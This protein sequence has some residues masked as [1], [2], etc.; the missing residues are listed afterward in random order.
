M[1][2]KVFYRDEMTVD[3]VE[4]FSPSAGKPQKAVE[5]WLGKNL[6]IE[7]VAPR[8]VDLKDV[9]LAHCNEFVEKIHHCEV[10]NGFGTRDDRVSNAVLFTCGAM[11]EAARC[12]VEE[13]IVTCAPVSGFHHAGYDFAQYY[14][15]YNGLMVAACKLN[16]LFDIRVGILDL[17]Q[18]I[19]DGTEDIISRINADFVSHHTQGGHRCHADMA[20]Q[21]LHGLEQLIETK[22]AD[23]GIVLYQAG[24]DPHID[25]PLGGWL[26]TEQLAWR[27]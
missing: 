22:F 1:K 2:I 3:G 27:D 24:A 7:V 8:P 19:G 26:T 12:A 6:T 18:H 5:A 17:D 21:F 25:D 16:Q 15:T 13:G 4:S 14:C 11:L 23:C 9:C 20:G 10:D